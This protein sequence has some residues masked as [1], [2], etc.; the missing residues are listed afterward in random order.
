[1]VYYTVDLLTNSL[2]AISNTITFEINTD[3]SRFELFHLCWKDKLGSWISY[4]FKYKSY[5]NEEFERKTYYQ[6][7][8]R[9]E[10][11]DF[12]YDKFGRGDTTYYSRSREKFSLNTGW[13]NEYENEL[14]KD[15]MSSS[16]VMMQDPDGNM[17]AVTIQNSDIQYGEKE[18]DYIWNYTIDVKLSYNE[19]RF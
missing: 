12:G 5:E 14:I 4:P 2:S 19:Y 18:N 6:K 15:L 17:R 11:N 10:G 3:C 8:G 16:S 13:I 1:V 7:E 9:Y